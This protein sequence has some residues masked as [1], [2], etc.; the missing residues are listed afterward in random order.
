MKVFPF[1]DIFVTSQPS[2]GLVLS[3]YSSDN[4][5]D[6]KRIKG[7]SDVMLPASRFVV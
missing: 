6:L 1:C 3:R 7:G 4:F 5:L 2:A